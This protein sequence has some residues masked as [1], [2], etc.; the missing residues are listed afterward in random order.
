MLGLEIGDVTV[1]AVAVDGSG[2]VRARAQETIDADAAAAALNA[3]RRVSVESPDPSVGIAA[4]NPDAAGLEAVLGSLKGQYAGVD[5]SRITLSGTAAAV[6]EAWVG[7]AA[8]A[9]DVAYLS[10]AEHTTA[11]IVR[12]GAPEMGAHGR[13]AAIAWLALNPVE[14]EDYRKSG[15]LE[16]EVAGAGIVRRLVWRIKAGDRSRI[17]EMVNGDLTA[18]TVEHVLQAARNGDGVSISVLRDTA[19]Y[20]GMAAANLVVIT[21][22]EALVLGGIVA[23]ASDLLM[24]PVKTEI[25]RRLPEPTLKSLMIATATL[26]A[27]AAAIGAARLNDRSLR[28]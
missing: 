13:A 9:Q 27:D 7:A 16:A 20:V 21:D 8:G 1:V 25:A 11:G 19:K 2:A 28:R 12:G 24:D 5:G 26:G 10:I 22:P 17:Q 6:A 3:L 23:T 4:M 15:C 14:R 18:I